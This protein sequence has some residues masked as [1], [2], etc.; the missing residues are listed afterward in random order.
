MEREVGKL[1]FIGKEKDQDIGRERDL[2]K[3]EYFSFFHE[4]SPI[5][6][7]ILSKWKSINWC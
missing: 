2:E 7:G 5:Y 1:E 6:D 3:L 4:V